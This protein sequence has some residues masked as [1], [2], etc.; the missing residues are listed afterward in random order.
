MKTIT[1]PI[2][3]ALCLLLIKPVKAQ[4][5]EGK[6]QLSTCF[7]TITDLHGKKI[8]LLRSQGANSFTLKSAGG[9]GAAWG[10]IVNDHGNTPEIYPHLTSHWGNIR[11]Y[12]SKDLYSTE[13]LKYKEFPQGENGKVIFTLADGIDKI[14]IRMIKQY[15]YFD[16]GQPRKYLYVS[17]EFEVEFIDE[18]DIEVDV[19]PSNGKSCLTFN[20][21]AFD[22][23]FHG[24]EGLCV[25]PEYKLTSKS[26]KPDYLGLPLGWYTRWIGTPY[27]W[28]NI[29]AHCANEPN[30]AHCTSAPH[31]PEPVP[32]RCI[33]FDLEIKL[34]SCGGHHIDCPP[35]HIKKEI[36]ICCS[37]D[38]RPPADEE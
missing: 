21:Y 14:N 11:T 20:N 27:V 10:I 1:L 25:L 26:Q 22:L 8:K 4:L 13:F 16:D 23:D 24:L 33:P 15:L 9:T 2:C 18:E 17:A 6:L 5:L 36:E 30:G 32:C 12:E 34:G 7:Q 38:V 29:P 19:V 35:I 31:L 28:P 37:C 3:L